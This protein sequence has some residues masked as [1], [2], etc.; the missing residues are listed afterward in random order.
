MNPLPCR[1]LACA[2]LAL[3]PLAARADSPSATASLSETS[4]EV[5]ET[6]EYRIDVVGAQGGAAPKAPQVE[7]LTITGSGRSNSTQMTGSFGSGVKVVSSTI[8]TFNVEASHAG[9]FVIPG[10]EIDTGAGPVRV[11]PVAFTATGGGAGAA[12]A[13]DPSRSFFARLRFG[14]P[15]AFVGEAFPAEVQAFFGADVTFNIDPNVSLRG[16][17]FT[18]QKFTPPA[19]DVQRVDGAQYRVITYRSSLAGAKT[20]TLSVS[21]ADV[22]AIV[23]LPRPPQPRR[24]PTFSN[25]FDDDPFF[26]DPFGALNG[27][28]TKQIK[29]RADPQPLEIKPLPPGAPADFTGAIGHFTLEAEAEPRKAQAGDPVTVH[30]HLSGDGNFD[31]V[32]AP[33]VNDDQGLHLYPPSAK[34]KADDDLG[35]KGT[36]TFEQAV[37]AQTARPSLPGYHFSYL[38]PDTGKYVTINTAALPVVIEGSAAPVATPA[39]ALPSSSA[40]PAPAPIQ[41][42]RDILYIRSDAGPAADFAPVYRRRGFWLAQ[43]LA[44]AGL[45][46]FGALGWRRARSR[47][48]AARRAADSQRR[49][50]ELLKAL[51]TEG[52]ARRDFYSAATR[53]AQLKAGA[54]TGR[55]GEH[56]SLAEVCAAPRLDLQTAASVERIFHRHDEL[57]YSGGAVAQEPVPPEERRTVLETLETF[58]R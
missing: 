13:A 1:L 6:V 40:S 9:R 35:L 31:R 10:Q 18:I 41:K 2:A 16:E 54:A 20:G 5:G 51:R 32:S 33:A 50:A 12:A 57:A 8:Y 22:N 44:A 49:Q 43:G 55:P 42:P 24:R 46:A 28:V 47:N 30:L 25:P 27:T 53:L 29:L 37:V 14:K 39:P 3:A 52:T 45:A 7:G 23:R 34:F 11:E 58:G 19:Q 26:R 4:A 56:L 36:K 38:D 21:L 17:G 48:D 15:S